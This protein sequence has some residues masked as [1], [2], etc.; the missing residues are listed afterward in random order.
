M[1]QGQSG[2]HRRR[3]RWRPLRGGARAAPRGWAARRIVEGALSDKRTWLDPIEITQLLQAYAIPIVPA[4]LAR[5]NGEAA[6]A[7]R[8]FLVKGGTV[9]VKIFSRDIIHKSDVGG[10][11]LNLTS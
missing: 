8:P 6:T 11:R 2:R 5:D 7:A 3:C 4:V 9:A 1:V 10:V